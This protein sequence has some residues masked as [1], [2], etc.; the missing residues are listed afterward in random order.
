[1]PRQRAD[2]LAAHG[3]ALVGH[4]RGADLA[5]GEGL[6]E[7]LLVGHEAQVRRHFCGALGYAGEDVQEEGIYLPRIGLARYWQDPRK[8]HVRGDAPLE[9]VGLFRVPTEEG[10]KARARTGRTLAAVELQALQLKVQALEVEHEVLQP[11]AGPL[12]Q[13]GGLGGLVMRIGQDGGILLRQG[14]VCQRADDAQQQTAD[15]FH[16]VAE[17][18]EVAVVVHVAACCAQ[19]DDAARLRAVLAPGADVG[20]DVVAQLALIARSGGVVYDAELLPQL[21][22]LLLRHGQAELHLVLGQRQPEPLPGR[23]LVIRGEYLLHPLRSIARAERVFISV[24]LHRPPRL[25]KSTSVYHTCASGTI[26]TEYSV[27]GIS[28][29]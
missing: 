27:C 16:G 20:H 18:D 25:K 1:M 4:G 23:E 28:I 9:L 13:G 14:E 24:V 15:L 3:V 11:H 21:V 12:A 5:L 29:L 26:R 17:G 2:A 6:V 19:V 7:L 10:E 22:H 8:A